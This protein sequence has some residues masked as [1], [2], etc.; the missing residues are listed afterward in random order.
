MI[1]IPIIITITALVLLGLIYLNQKKNVCEG[2]STNASTSSLS[3]CPTSTKPFFEKSGDTLCCN[4]TV[5]GNTCVGKPVCAL[6]SSHKSLP[7]CQAF[8]KT[9]LET[10]GK[11]ICPST[12]PNYF[13]NQTTGING[14]TDGPLN[15]NMSGPN[16]NSANMCTLYTDDTKNLK[17]PKSCYNQKNLADTSC[18]GKECTKSLSSQKNSNTNLVMV[19]FS[20][21][22]GHKHTCYTKESYVEYL[23]HSKPGW[24]SGTFNPDKNISICEVAKK[25]YIDRTMNSKDAQL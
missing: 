22:D 3:F 23:N 15:T 21:L 10:Q 8:M 24:Q 4:G 14:C 1:K 11:K 12:M 6:S 16:L 2:F 17:D 7:T 18:F 13:E 20:D 25:V 5:Q 19:E 9:Y